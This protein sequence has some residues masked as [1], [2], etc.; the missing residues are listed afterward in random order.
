MKSEMDD[1]ERDSDGVNLCQYFSLTRCCFFL[2]VFFLLCTVL[3]GVVALVVIFVV[4]PKKPIFALRSI[5]LDTL[6]FNS[7]SSNIIYASSNVSLILK[8]QNPNKI[9]GLSY[10][11]SSFDVLYE[12]IPIG[13]ME[14][15][16]FYQ[17]PRS[18]NVSV[19]MHVLFDHVNV[20]HIIDNLLPL[21]ENSSKKNSSMIASL[22]KLR[23]SIIELRIVG[24]IAAHVHL[25]HITFPK[26]KVSLDCQMS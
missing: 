24:Y 4:K 21:N 12:W 9:M 18:T 5:R 2:L 19:E 1:V 13:N 15:S 11:H 7:S 14:V 17:P 10:Q 6:D 8:A 16:K 23:S 22:V 20:T 25:W 26:I 3:T